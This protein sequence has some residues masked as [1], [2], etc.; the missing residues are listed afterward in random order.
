MLSKSVRS[1]PWI[2]P[3]TR[4]GDPR[5]R[6]RSIHCLFVVEAYCQGNILGEPWPMSVKST[7]NR[8]PRCTS[9]TLW[10]IKIFQKVKSRFANLK[11]K[12]FVKRCH[13]R[14]QVDVEPSIRASEPAVPQNE[15]HDFGILRTSTHNLKPKDQRLKNLKMDLCHQK[16]ARRSAK[17]WTGMGQRHQHGRY[18]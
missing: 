16:V 4:S 5:L 12:T 1:S 3:V 9:C 14:S 15:Q 18:R 11:E 17:K 10:E 13:R 7:A 6:R 2:R 8:V